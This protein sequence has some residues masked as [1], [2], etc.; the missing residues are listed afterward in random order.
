LLCVLASL[1]SGCLPASPPLP[2]KR[3]LV[4]TPQSAYLP[5]P[6][7]Q[8]PPE[9]ETE[10][11]A[12]AQEAQGQASDR[13][14]T[15]ELLA[16]LDALRARMAREAE[17][18]N[19]LLEEGR[20]EERRLQEE[21]VKVLDRD[22][23]QEEALHGAQTEGDLAASLA[24]A[25]DA[26]RAQEEAIRLQREALEAQERQIQGQIEQRL[27]AHAQAQN[28]L[29]ATLSTDAPVQGEVVGLSLTN[30]RAGATY[31]VTA[32]HL[33]GGVTLFEQGDR[34]IGIVEVVPE[35]SAGAHT[36]TVYETQGGQRRVALELPY[37]IA[38]VTFTR[39]DLTV[40]GELSSIATAE[41]YAH[42]N[43]AIGAAKA[44]T[45]PAPLWQGRFMQP[46]EGR[47][48]TEYGQARYTN[49][50]FSSRHS[51]IDI[52]AAEGTPVYAAANGRVVL[53]EELIV[54]GKTVILDH[55]M[56][57]FTTYSHLS[58]IAVAVGENAD[59][60]A[61]IGAV[62]ATGYATGPHLHYAASIKAA[63]VNPDLL[64]ERDPLG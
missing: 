28:S 29:A 1:L 6:T 64:R 3:T 44:N 30:L 61:L 5:I 58:E 41:N 45:Y 53:A 19:A 52:A 50:T 31:E 54:S 48:S 17:E 22:A 34:L 25:Q 32:S 24:R 33:E 38:A 51:A 47:V 39:Q 20:S 7:W 59:M 21:L 16:Q 46:T 12:D 40:S 27:D 23:A 60:G 14:T 10:P 56:W 35:S 18:L 11:E 42:D 13:T 9:E 8:T 49:G 62:G 57:L 26:L 2:P 63:R 55:G 37:T 15:D 4:S 36:L 43:R